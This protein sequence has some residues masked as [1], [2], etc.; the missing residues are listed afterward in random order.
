MPKDRA[1]KSESTDAFERAVGEKEARKLK[2]R[3]RPS[4]SIWSGFAFFGLIGWSVAIPA[5]LGVALGVWIDK[6]HPSS[7]SWTLVLLII[8][9]LLGC[10]NAWRWV[11]REHQDMR[12]EAEEDQ[13]E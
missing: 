3:R 5:L 11:A 4:P 9:L 2:A 10:L 13:D 12:S 8:G 1:S 6:H 7:H